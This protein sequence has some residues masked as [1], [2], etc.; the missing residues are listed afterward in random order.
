[1]YCERLCA[2]TT[3][4]RLIDH[5]SSAYLSRQDARIRTKVWPEASSFC[6]DTEGAAAKYISVVALLFH[7]FLSHSIW[8]SFRLSLIL[9]EQNL[10][11]RLSQQGWKTAWRHLWQ[12]IFSPMYYAV[13]STACTRVKFSSCQPRKRDLTKSIIKIIYCELCETGSTFARLK[14]INTFQLHCSIHTR[15][16]AIASD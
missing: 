11:V 5:V 9:L 10:K 12:I 2:A 14:D 1:M 3:P 15:C 4:D 8:M 6:M 16:S 7:I 13:K